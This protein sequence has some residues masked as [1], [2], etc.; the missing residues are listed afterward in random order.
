[1]RQ[2]VLNKLRERQEI[3]LGEDCDGT[4]QS[5]NQ[6]SFFKYTWLDREYGNSREDCC[7]S[8]ETRL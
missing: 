7:V 4:A 8:N 3:G 2:T 1:M 5:F 6:K